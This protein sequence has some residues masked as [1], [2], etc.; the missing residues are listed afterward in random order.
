MIVSFLALV[1]L[2]IVLS[3]LWIAWWLVADLFSGSHTRPARIIS[4]ADEHERSPQT[5]ARP[6]AIGD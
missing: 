5:S 3:V 2:G 6:K 1:V 4:A